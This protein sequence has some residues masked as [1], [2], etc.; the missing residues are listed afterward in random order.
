MASSSGPKPPQRSW[1]DIAKIRSP[2]QLRQA[3]EPVM[4][5]DE[6]LR[7]QARDASFGIS[8]SGGLGGRT[9]E[10]VEFEIFQGILN[11]R[12]NEVRQ[13]A[14]EEQKIKDEREET[15]AKIRAQREQALKTK[16]R[17]GRAQF[18]ISS[19]TVGGA[20]SSFLTGGS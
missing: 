2:E 3:Q 5:E 13:R 7:Q 11:N 20:S 18:L 6:R 14:L 12:E 9:R 1:A 15:L 4:T 8:Q 19:R 10:Q 17:P 16:E